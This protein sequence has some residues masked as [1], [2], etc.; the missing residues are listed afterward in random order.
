MKEKHT[1]LITGGCGFIG[2]NFIK[3]LIEKD[4]V[5]QIVC[6]DNLSHGNFLNGI[7]DNPKVAFHEEDIL[8]YGEL[9][10]F[11]GY[12]K[13]D[14]VFHFAGLVSIYDCFKNPH[15][16]FENNIMGS[17]NIFELCL[18]YDI[19]KVIISETSA[20]YEDSKILPHIEEDWVPKT[21]YSAS[22]ACMHMIAESY[23]KTKGLVYTGLR[24]FN[25]YGET[26]DFSRTVPPASCGF[27]IR[28]MQRKNPIIFGDGNR[29]RDFI[30]VD[31]VNRFHMMCI[32]DS[33]TDNDVFNIGT[34]ESISL[35]EMIDKIAKCLSIDDY[36]I[37]QA[38]E[39]AGEAFDIKANIEKAEALGWKPR[40]SFEEGHNSLILY[41]KKLFEEGIFP[42]DFMD[43][44]DTDSVKI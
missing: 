15:K 5:K 29:R 36:K 39:I 13:P 41:L 7:H 1:I 20:M 38:P 26:Q 9:D 8:N 3:D 34:G 24:Y 21:T 40:V 11:F 6:I 19:K 14:Y 31:D 17:V 44:I 42:D 10:I 30:H 12:Y 4:S 43:N 27:G 35:Y 32:E 28:L 2:T 37:T 23:K 33:R 25:V 18:K 16:A 22:K